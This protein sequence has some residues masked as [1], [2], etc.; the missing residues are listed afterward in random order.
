MT[1]AIESSKKRK[2][3][4]SNNSKGRGSLVTMLSK[5]TVNKIILAIFEL[6]R[7]KIK[8]ELGDRQFSIQVWYLKII[9]FLNM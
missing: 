1:V 9:F 7:R 4:V 3:N 8:F 5:N 6:I 2:E